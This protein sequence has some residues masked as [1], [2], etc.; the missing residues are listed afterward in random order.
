MLSFKNKGISLKFGLIFILLFFQ[1]V[2]VFAYLDF[3]SKDILS[4]TAERLDESDNREFASWVK[5]THQDN[6]WYV[7]DN[8]A[9][10]RLGLTFGSIGLKLDDLM[11]EEKIAYRGDEAMDVL[12]ARTVFY[13]Q[14]SKIYE[15]SEGAAKTYGYKY[16]KFTPIM[17]SSIVLKKIS[18]DGRNF[19]LEGDEP[20]ASKAKDEKISW[21][22]KIVMFFKKE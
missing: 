21:W 3:E 8:S 7:I 17:G 11:N 19:Y 18:N 15:L 10:G 12:F 20:P 16:F 9:K 2:S 14:Y 6:T 13:S 5:F 1:L 4:I 22:Q